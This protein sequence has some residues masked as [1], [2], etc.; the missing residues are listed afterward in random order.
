[1]S[2]VLA[3]QRAVGRVV[4]VQQPLRDA[5]VQHDEKS[6]LANPSLFVLRMPC[7]ACVR[8]NE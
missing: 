1:M 8:A 3:D 2:V 5:L 7:C 6:S 4:E